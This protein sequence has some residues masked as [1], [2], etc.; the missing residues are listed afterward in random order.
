MVIFRILIISTAFLV[1]PFLNFF[2]R[3]VSF[4]FNLNGNLATAIVRGKL[5]GLYWRCKDLKIE[6][7]TL[8]IY[9]RNIFFSDHVKI[10]SGVQISAY[11]NTKVEIGERTHIAKDSII[12]GFAGVKIGDNCAI[13]SGVRIYTVSND[14]KELDVLIINQRSV[15]PINISDNVLIGA[16]TII[17]PGV[18]IG[19]N[20]VVAAGSVVNKDVGDNEIVGGSPIRLIKKRI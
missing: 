1:E 12:S 13:S 15:G 4:A 9:P 3:F 5:Y 10:Y 7:N 14:I 8:F 17:F 19:K 11:K 2:S 16:G 6:E 18:K 20:S